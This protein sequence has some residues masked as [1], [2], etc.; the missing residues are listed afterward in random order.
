MEMEEK[1]QRLRGTG[2]RAGDKEPA[3]GDV[4]SVGC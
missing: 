4:E 3:G 1:N 2:G